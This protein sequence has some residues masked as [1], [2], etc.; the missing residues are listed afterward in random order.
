MMETDLFIA[1]GGPS[2]LAAA[3]A[4][5]RSGFVVTVA[6]VARPPI[7]KACGEGIMP[8]GLAALAE[9]GVTLPID[10]T[11]P[12]QGIRFL[13]SE[14]SVEARFAN[15]NGLGIRRT[16]LHQVLVD[17]A[18]QAG[19]SMHWGSRV[20]GLTGDG[21]LLD[22]R[23][24]R[25]RW[26]VG[27]DGLQSH[28]RS[29]AGLEGSA[30]GSIRFGFR[31]HF[32]V[33]PWSE[34][35]EVHWTTNGQLYITP[36]SD[37][38]ICVALVT[39]DRGLRLE[40]AIAG[41]SSLPRQLRQAAAATRE[42]GAISASRTLKAVVRGSRALIGE[43]SGCVDAVTG[44]GLSLAFRQA[45]ALEKAL[46]EDELSHYQAEHRKLMRLPRVMAGLMLLMDRRHGLRRRAL[47]AFSTQP[48]SFR[49]VL[50]I[51]TGAASP[52]AFGLRG[53]TSFG[54]RMLTA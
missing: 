14:N 36:I 7:D 41:C 37:D 53:T 10:K 40:R 16:V 27:A 43:A 24:I 49:R 13:D 39:R 23:K 19:V 52:L 3:I 42:Q 9:L 11:A 17:H 18:Q 4:A 45:L 30:A 15:G 22:D 5:R 48:E 20:T 29:W 21:V 51:H 54:W 1:G 32:L 46:R 34:F 28:V 47:R 44:E 31:R 26:V 50:A 6:D 2:G 25:C 35:V 38:E 12:F 33:K 8:D